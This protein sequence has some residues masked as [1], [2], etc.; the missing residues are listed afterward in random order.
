M[1]GILLFTLFLGIIFAVACAGEKKQEQKETTETKPVEIIRNPAH[2]GRFYPADPEELKAQVAGFL[3]NAKSE[4]QDGILAITVP[5][6]GYVYSGKVAGEAFKAASNSR[7]DTIILIGPYHYGPL[8]GAAVFTSGKFLSP[9]GSSVIDETLAQLFLEK[10]KDAKDNPSPH[11]QEH[12]LENQLP[13]I[14]YIWGDIP[15]L[16]ILVGSGDKDFARELGKGLLA[17]IQE[18]GKKL[19]IVSTVD[20]SHYYP[21]DV[22]K[23]LDDSAL[24][25][26]ADSDPLRIVDTNEQGISAVDAPLVFGAV[27]YAMRE[28]G[29]SKPEILCYATSADYNNDTSKVVGYSAV[30]WRKE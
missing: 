8:S 18:S 25:A 30:V 5:H 9:L 17:L 16:P 28:L 4:P 27:N 14:H 15:I 19:L 12:S 22:A 24:S 21:L 1:R 20:L 3:D 6:A 11:Y 13:F 29:V 2:A 10:V 23:T 26:L 7:P